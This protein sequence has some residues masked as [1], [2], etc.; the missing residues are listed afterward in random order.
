MKDSDNDKKRGKQAAPALNQ[1]ST[2][3]TEGIVSLQAKESEQE[4]NIIR[5]KRLKYQSWH[6]GCKETDV[7]L[8]HFC[9]VYLEAMDDHALNEFEAI[10]NEDDADLYRWLTGEQPV[11]EDLLSNATLQRL[12]QF[13]VEPYLTGRA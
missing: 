12:L 13:D 6:R 7:I 4:T 2:E 11:P 5:K 10:L 3:G 8:G 9:D 1:P